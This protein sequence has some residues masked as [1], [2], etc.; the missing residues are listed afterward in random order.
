MLGLPAPTGSSHRLGRCAGHRSRQIAAAQNAT[1]SRRASS[2]CAGTLLA[3]GAVPSIRHP[4]PCAV[5]RAV[6]STPWHGVA[7]G[8]ARRERFH[9]DARWI[10]GK[11]HDSVL[12]FV[13]TTRVA[14][15]PPQRRPPRGRVAPAPRAW[16]RSSSRTSAICSGSRA[17]QATLPVVSRSV[18]RSTRRPLAASAVVAGSQRGARRVPD[19]VAVASRRRGARLHAMR[20]MTERAAL[21][22]PTSRSRGISPTNFGDCRHSSA[23]SNEEH[24]TRHQG[25]KL[26]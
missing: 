9:V 11:L 6:T 19:D 2:I 22:R 25:R 5:R 7:V 21:V 17:A 4:V 14:A 24:R 10:R 16:K 1:R 13:L 8:R 18:P 26:A 23:P 15:G 3:I 20:C 12:T